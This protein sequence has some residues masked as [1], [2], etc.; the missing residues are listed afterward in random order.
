[1]RSHRAGEELA[2]LEAVVSIL[3]K[4][5]EQLEMRLFL[6]LLALLGAAGT[7]VGSILAR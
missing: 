2:R 6:L 1:M 5:I 3:Q 4:R 7:V